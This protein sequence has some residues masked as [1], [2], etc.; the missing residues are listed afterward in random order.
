MRRLWD[1]GAAV[2]YPVRLHGTEVTMEFIGDADIA[3]PRLVEAA[4]SGSLAFPDLWEQC[5]E[6]LRTMVRCGIVHADLSPYNLLVWR[7]VLYVI[8]LPQCVDLGRHDQDLDLLQR[9]VRN[10]CTF[11]ARHGVTC[12]PEEVFAELVALVPWLEGG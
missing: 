3:A 12:D 7:D 1:A 10:V 11:F 8:D 6:L 9:D 4:R 5:R 2:P